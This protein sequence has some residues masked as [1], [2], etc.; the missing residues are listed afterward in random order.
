M[1]LPNSHESSQKYM[2]LNRKS[3]SLVASVWAGN[4][5]SVLHAYIAS[6]W[7]RNLLKSVSTVLKFEIVQ[8][9]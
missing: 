5:N 3:L 4:L 9:V 1:T 2:D 8:A 6:T 7:L